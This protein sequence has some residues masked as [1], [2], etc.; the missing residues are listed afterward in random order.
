[1]TLSECLAVPDKLFGLRPQA[2]TG[3]ACAACK[4]PQKM[5]YLPGIAVFLYGRLRRQH[6]G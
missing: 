6:E 3:K 2:A 1:M 4:P 5:A